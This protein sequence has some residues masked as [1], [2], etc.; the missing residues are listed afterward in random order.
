MKKYLVGFLYS[1]PVQLVLLHFRRYQVLLIF[2]YVLFSVVNGSFL[3]TYGAYTLFLSPEYLGQVNALSTSMIG[4]SIG[5][6]I[7]SWNITT[8]ILH[9][10]HLKFLATTANPLLKF[11]INNAVIPVLFLAFYLY[12]AVEFNRYQQLEL[13][14][15]YCGTRT[16][17]C[18]G[19]NGC[20]FYWVCLFFWC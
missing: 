12:K 4:I 3:K 15:A 6:F 13:Y 10:K 8:F 9:G 17:V 19:T 18:T 20:C 11:C 14:Y 5:I 7:M 2:W 16:W 1:L